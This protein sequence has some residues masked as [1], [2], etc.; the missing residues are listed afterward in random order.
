VTAVTLLG[1]RYDGSSSFLRGAA[2]AP[3]LIREARWT[4]AGN[5]WAEDGTDLGPGGVQGAGDGI[6]EKQSTE[7]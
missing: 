2:D 6:A 3:P 5:S 7:K 4:D 1:I